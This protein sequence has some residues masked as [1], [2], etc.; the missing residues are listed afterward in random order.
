[1]EYFGVDVSKDSL[2]VS[3]RQGSRKRLSAT[4]ARALPASLA[5]SK[6]PP[7]KTALT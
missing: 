2:Q 1:M 3:D 5:G 6:E 7:A 4:P